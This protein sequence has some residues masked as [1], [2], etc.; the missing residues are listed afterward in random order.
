VV[1]VNVL[2]THEVIDDAVEPPVETPRPPKPPPRPLPG[3]LLAMKKWISPSATYL[4][5]C[6]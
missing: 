4:R 3:P 6:A 2:S 5:N 1:A